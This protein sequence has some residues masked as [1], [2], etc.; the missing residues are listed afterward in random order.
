VVTLT[1]N[2][3]LSEGESG[4]A[5]ITFMVNPDATGAIVNEAQLDYEDICG[6]AWEPIFANDTDIV[7]E[8]PVIEVFQD[9][10]T[11]IPNGTGTATFVGSAGSPIVSTIEIRNTGTADLT[12]T[13]P[14]SLTGTGFS[15]LG[16]FGTTTVAPGSSTSFSV[17]CDAVDAGVFTGSISFENGDLIATPFTFALECQVDSALIEVFQ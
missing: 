6:C 13:E 14:I 4:T 17:Q 9:G 3:A 2:E 1:I 15:L 5:F 7:N 16:T 11:P 8:I 10:F 12:L